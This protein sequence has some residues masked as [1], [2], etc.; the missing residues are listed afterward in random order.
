[1]LSTS[2]S[3]RLW[4]GLQRSAILEAVGFLLAMVAI[5]Q[6][7]LDGDRF[8]DASPHPF[9]IVV[10]LV[11][12]QYG[13]A[14]GIASAILSSVALLLWNVPSQSIAQDLYAHLWQVAVN[15]FLWILAA[16]VLGELRMRGLRY[17]QK[18]QRDLDAVEQ[19]SGE[20]LTS[21]EETNRAKSRLETAVASQLGSAVNLYQAAKGLEASDP[22]DVLLGVPDLA[23][24]IMN[25]E[26][27]SVF[28][29]DDNTL[30]LALES[31]WGSEDVY[32]KAFV[33][34][35][36]LFQK[37]VGERRV[38][39]VT[40]AEDEAFLA[41]QGLLAGPLIDG[42]TEEI[43][44]M[45]KVERL[46][47][48]DLNFST[49]QNFQI[50]CDWVATAYAR[51]KRNQ[52][53]EFASS[54]DPD[55]QPLALSLYDRQKDF[56][57]HLARRVPFD[58]SRIT[59][60]LESR[61]DLTEETW[62]AISVAVRACVRNA[63]RNTDLVFETPGNRHE[64]AILLPAT[65]IRD[66]KAMVQGFR[67]TLEPELQKEERWVEMSV[68]AQSLEESARPEGGPVATDSLLG[69]GERVGPSAAGPSDD[70]GPTANPMRSNREFSG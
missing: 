32:R 3:P 2:V 40:N 62:A 41:D 58:L 16:L 20:L 6:F 55:R 56:L 34:D 15:P 64:F 49:I 26:R 8:W 52:H 39:S 22:N 17:E 10:A 36:P 11:T 69:L 30:K 45:L 31:G 44:G 25:P 60:R 70:P 35:T 43:V 50:L 19:K 29:M 18:L 21:L 4:F 27:L 9:W 23:A 33:S 42:A 51:A 61:H 13:T 63:L 24:S 28:L 59:L 14:E 7:L 65:P 67:E 38:V 37:V 68:T 54:A 1:M 66:A 47:F 48:F 5:D 12:V 53:A 57:T 46:G